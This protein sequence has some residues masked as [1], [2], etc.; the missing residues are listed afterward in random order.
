MQTVRHR[1]LSAVK[2]L[3]YEDRRFGEN[4]YSRMCVVRVVCRAVLRTDCYIRSKSSFSHFSLKGL[5]T[6]RCQWLNDSFFIKLL[7]NCDHVTLEVSIQNQTC[8]RQLMR[9]IKHI[10]T[11][12]ELSFGRGKKNIL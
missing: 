12:Q 6:F 2:K 4:P 3:Q 9:E 7:Q 8:T 5:P 10:I 1:Y 11:Y